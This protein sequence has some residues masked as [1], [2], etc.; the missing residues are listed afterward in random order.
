M[1]KKD[2]QKLKEK[3]LRKY[4]LFG[5][6]LAKYPLVI[7]NQIETAGTD[8]KNIVFNQEFLNTLTE[9]QAL[10]LLAHEL[11]HLR[12]AHLSRFKTLT[13]VEKNF[14]CWNIATDAVI[15]ANLV[16]DGFEMIEGGID[17]P[18]AINYTSEQVYKYLIKDPNRYKDQ[19]PLDNHNM[20]NNKNKSS[21][22][23]NNSNTN[24]GN[25][26]ANQNT[27]S[28]DNN[29][30]KQD[31]QSQNNNQQNQNESGKNQDN[32]QNSNDETKNNSDGSKN[33]DSSKDKGQSKDKKSKGNKFASSKR[34]DESKADGNENQSYSTEVKDYDSEQYNEQKMFEENRKVRKQIASEKLEKIKQNLINQQGVKPEETVKKSRDNDVCDWR[35]LLKR[36]FDEEDLVWSQRRS[37]KANNY[38]YRIEDYI[39]DDRPITE[40]I[41]D[42]SS[43]IDEELLKVFL[44]QIKSLLCDTDIIVGTFS[45]N[46][47]GW[48]EVRTEKDIDKLDLSIG[49]GTNFDE[50][51]KAFSLDP[52]T[53]KIC[54]TDGEDYGNAEITNKR[55]DIIW[56]CFENKDFKPDYGKVIY[57]SPT[58]IY[59]SAR[60]SDEN[61]ER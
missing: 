41:L 27:Q 58:Q 16:K 31:S 8:G 56:V 60:E 26:Q 51:S 9:S 55:R 33:D 30:T 4:P 45:N 15:N 42:T 53:N 54:F 32:S 10:F 59:D 61:L 2:L 43:S 49:G 6:E 17:M 11:L 48:Q 14:E 35:L 12:F 23:N 3:F 24:N 20:W 7:N 1:E 38:G 19:K 46:F 29:Q 44:K 36:E 47:H 50:A 21:S 52:R 39:S 34:G 25:D 13:N 37:V 22:N 40:V 28:Q 18:W 5:E 57:V